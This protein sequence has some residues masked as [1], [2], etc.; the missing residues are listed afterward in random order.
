VVGKVV[1]LGTGILK[2]T[3]QA[4]ERI[5]RLM[6]SSIQP[7]FGAIPDR[8]SET[9]RCANVKRTEEMLGWKPA[10]FLD[11]GLERTIEWYRTQ[12]DRV[13]VNSASPGI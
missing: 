5:V 2:T 4:V 11:E 3:R 9:A 12:L 10:V 6:G 13:A 7:A 1:D 8:A